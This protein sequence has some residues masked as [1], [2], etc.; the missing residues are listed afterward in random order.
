[1]KMNKENYK[2]YMYIIT[3][4]ALL[5]LLLQNIN[6][7]FNLIGVVLTISYPFIL[8]ACIAFVLHI[9]MKF[10]EEKLFKNK[11]KL[12]KSIS[13]L[14]AMLSVVLIMIV[15]M[16]L[17]IPELV[18][19]FSGIG[20]SFNVFVEQSKVWLTSNFDNPTFLQMVNSI[21]L[22]Y[23]A[24][25]NDVMSFVQMS[26]SNVLLSSVAITA[27]I[28]S[29]VVN[30]LIA[31]I[32]AIYILLQKEALYRQLKKVMYAFFNKSFVIKF[33]EVSSL[34]YQT[35]CNFIAGQCLEAIILGT[36]FFVAMLI[37]QMPY[38]LLVGVL[39]CVTALIPIVG[40][41]IGCFVGAFL[42]LMQNPMQAVLFIILFVIIQQIEGNL[43][44]PYVVGNSVGL[45]SIWVL[46]SVTI[47]G[48]LFGIVGMLIAIP[49]VSVMYTLFKNCV[50]N[51]LIKRKIEVK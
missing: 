18:S 14:L 17:V 39:L 47:G 34:S 20:E 27:S 6:L 22:N 26:A 7:V 33:Y 28:V 45:P 41:F 23:E 44:Y 4:V 2:Y 30:L 25:F 29:F 11:N 37:L 43:I 38:A 8:G 42:I 21:D 19:T 48:S 9:P 13:L 31:I 15:V 51:R 49:I 40:A 50:T 36:M 3:F 10:F 35:F 46:V 5:F 32:F 1:M 16:F 24:I 12:S